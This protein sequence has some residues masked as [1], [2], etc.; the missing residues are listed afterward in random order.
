MM[1]GGHVGYA[2]NNGPAWNQ[3]NPWDLEVGDK[4]KNVL[5]HYLILVRIV[6]RFR[7]TLYCF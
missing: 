1:G 4:A 7:D 6:E 5:Y 2:E 3:A